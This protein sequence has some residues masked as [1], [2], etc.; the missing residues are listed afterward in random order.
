MEVDETDSPNPAVN[1]ADLATAVPAAAAGVSVA[2]GMG[3]TA[4]A[5]AAVARPPQGPVGLRFLLVPHFK[6]PSPQQAESE[7]LALGLQPE[8]HR[9]PFYGNAADKPQQPAVFAG[10]EFR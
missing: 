1:H 5:A 6:P 2:A 7:L 4:A 8:V 9:E 3:D 10:R